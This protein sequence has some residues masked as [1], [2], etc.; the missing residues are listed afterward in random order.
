[1]FL[2]LKKL[3]KASEIYN[4]LEHRAQASPAEALAKAGLW[5]KS[6]ESSEF[7]R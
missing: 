4:R 3:F 6:T 2:L 7:Y 5:A 1:M